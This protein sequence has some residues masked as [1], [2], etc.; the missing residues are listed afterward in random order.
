[1]HVEVVRLS[2]LS[3]EPALCAAQVTGGTEHLTVAARHSRSME[4]AAAWLPAAPTA[5]L[6]SLCLPC[7]QSPN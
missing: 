6:L 1:M 3:D 2:L 4:A 5:C 7:F